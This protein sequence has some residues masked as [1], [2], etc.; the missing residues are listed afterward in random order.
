LALLGTGVAAGLAGIALTLLL[1]VVQHLAFKYTEDTFLQGVIEASPVRRVG[2]LAAGGV[3][4]GVGWWLL[5]RFTRRHSVERAIS[6]EPAPLPVF[7]TTLDSCLQVI[8]VGL[9]ASLGRE[10]APRQLAAAI[11]GWLAERCRLDAEQ[12]RIVIAAGAGAGLAAVYNVPL[13][14]CVFAAEVLLGSLSRRTLIPAAVASAVATAVSWLVLPNVPIYVVGQLPLTGSLLVWSVLAGPVVGSAGW[15]FRRLTTWAR[16]ARPRGW[17]LIL[18]A[19]PTF[20]ALGLLAA[21]LPAL[22]GNGKGAM[23]LALVGPLGL[24]TAAAL[25]VLKPVVTAACLRSGAEGG[26]LTP[27]LSTGA[28]L[29]VT[30]GLLWT[31]IWPGAAV[32]AFAVV[33]AA[34][35]LAVTQRSPLCA[36]VLAIE[37]THSGL[38]LLVPI[39]VAVGLASATDRLLPRARPTVVSAGQ[40]DLVGRPGL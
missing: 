37:L 4:A 35:M 2:A 24:G 31:L 20:A 34:A 12:R 23:Q 13:A 1:H 29:G 30:T 3:V 38:T 14:G 32:G 22:L 40:K 17:S 25:A 9:G 26:L 6:A 11:G 36:V 39:L 33:G 19:V 10:G 27:S 28:L 7:S 21:W 5:R 8:V 15:A 16:A 18:A